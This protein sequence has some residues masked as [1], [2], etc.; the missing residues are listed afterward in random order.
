MKPVELQGSN[1]RHEAGSDNLEGQCKPCQETGDVAADAGAHSQQTREEREHSEEQS[2]DDEGE[3]EPRGQVVV[4]RSMDIVSTRSD[5]VK[6]NV[7][8]PNKLRGHISSGAKVVRVRRVEG[9]V[10]VRLAADT[11]AIARHSTDLPE[12]PAR[13]G[14]G[15]WDVARV[16]LEEVDLVQRVGIASTTQQCEE[17]QQDGTGHEEQADEAQRH[18]YR[19]PISILFSLPASPDSIPSHRDRTYC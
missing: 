7:N 18:S 11:P 8:I 17:D 3:H 12:R 13:R 19:C 2:D 10:W 14:R 16:G 1:V 4:L 9:E 5:I 6:A 15:A